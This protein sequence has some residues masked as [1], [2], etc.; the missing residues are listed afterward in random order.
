MFRSEDDVRRWLKKKAPHVWWIENKR[1]GTFGMPDAVVPLPG[2]RIAWLELKLIRLNAR[3]ERTIVAE[4]AQLNIVRE[5]RSL[6]LNAWFMGGVEGE[7]R[8]EFFGNEI[9]IPQKSGKSGTS[10]NAESVKI[11]G[12]NTYRF[13]NVSGKY[14]PGT[15]FGIFGGSGFDEIWPKLVR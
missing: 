10:R 13:R 7:N 2:G 15:I 3:G 11:G 5:M 14:E 6:G 12:K 4:A 1:G 8:L 9:L